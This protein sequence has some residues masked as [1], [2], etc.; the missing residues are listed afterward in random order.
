MQIFE[1]YRDEKLWHMNDD[2]DPN[3]YDVPR[4]PKHFGYYQQLGRKKDLRFGLG[5]N[6]TPSVQ[7]P[8]NQGGYTPNTYNN[9]D[10]DSR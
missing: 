7:K 6:H 2:D 1:K 9:F 3:V 5:Q 8:I 10:R 4:Y